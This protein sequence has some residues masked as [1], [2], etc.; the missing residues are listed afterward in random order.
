MDPLF[1]LPRSGEIAT[2]PGYYQMVSRVGAKIGAPF[3]IAQGCR[4]PPTPER[5]CRW[6]FTEALT[7]PPALFD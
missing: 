4:M 7:E 6:V 1:N 5:G 2:R 3:R